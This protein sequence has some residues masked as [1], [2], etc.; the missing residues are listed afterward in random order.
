MHKN[1]RS[2]KRHVRSIKS[3]IRAKYGGRRN[4]STRA[5]RRHSHRRR[6]RTL[7]GGYSQYYNN[8]PNTP[9]YSTGGVLSSTNSAVT[10]L[11]KLRR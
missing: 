4:K 10:K 1:K 6:H 11:C 5:S 9:T 2:A 8:F 7:R 3:R